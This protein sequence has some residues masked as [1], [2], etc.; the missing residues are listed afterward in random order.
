M[1]SAAAGVAVLDGK[2]LYFGGETATA[3][4]ALNRTW[5]F[6]TN[7]ELWTELAPMNQGRHG[8]QAVVYENKVYIA[9]GSPVRG[10]GK[11]QSI[12]VF[13]F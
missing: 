10:G 3:G 9:A 6:D 2:I 11:T 7:T 13:S 12:E 5:I 8:S 1:G 4:P